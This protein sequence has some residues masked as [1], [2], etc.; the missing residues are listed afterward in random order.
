MATDAGGLTPEPLEPVRASSPDPRVVLWRDSATILVVVVLALLAWQ[1]F[2]RGGPGGPLASGDIPSGVV[3]G[4]LPP[5]MSLPPGVTFGP[6]VP[7]SLAIDATPTPIPVI[8]LG[9]P[10]PSPSVSPTPK[11]SAKPSG[12]PGATVITP[13]P[14]TGSTEPPPTD[15]PEPP[16]APP[17]I[18]NFT[19]SEPSPCQITFNNTSTGDSSWDWDFG[20]LLGSSSA[21]NPGYTYALGPATYSVKL[22]INGGADSITKSVVVDGSCPAP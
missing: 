14:P 2:A 6:V 20:D 16:T 17:V 4:S 12:T 18:A 8:T 13:P 19:Y 11:G 9:P 10:T 5:G 22:T 7:P 15:T 3:V 21:Q 1:T